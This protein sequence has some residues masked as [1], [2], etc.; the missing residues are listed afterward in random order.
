MKSF[1]F[2]AAL[3]TSTNALALFPRAEVP[4]CFNL[5][6]SGEVI[7]PLGQLTDGQSRVGD[8]SLSQSLF[9][10]NSTGVITDSTGKGCIITPET[11]Q[12]QCDEGKSGTPGFTIS[13]ASQLQF[14]GSE[15]FIACETGQNGGKNI[16]TTNSTSVTKCKSVIL[17]ADSC[18]NAGS[19]PIVGTSPAPAVP[20]APAP[21][22]TSVTSGAT[23]TA[24]APTGAPAATGAPA[25]SLSTHTSAATVIPVPVAP[26]PGQSSATSAG[27]ASPAA[28]SQ[29]SA[30]TTAHPTTPCPSCQ[31]ATS[32]A[33]QGTGTASPGPSCQSASSSSNHTCPSCSASG[34]NVTTTASGPFSSVT[35]F[36]N[37]T[38]ISSAPVTSLSTSI[39]P[40]SSVHANSTSTTAT[41]TSTSA[42]GCPTDLS[43]EFQ[44]PHLIV[45]IDSAKP[46]TPH[47]T[48]LN[49]TV[50]STVATTFNFDIPQSFSGKTCNLVF[51]FPR[52]EELQT[53][54][55]SFS[56]DGK[57]AFGK[58]SSTVTTSTTE[59][60]VPSVSQGLGTSAISP[61]HSFLISTFSCPA[62]QAIAFEMKSAG[63]T[64]FEFFE[65]WNPSPLGL[66]VTAC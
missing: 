20:V 50:N 4:C 62:G 12:F 35:G 56:G 17:T 11:T 47:G 39:H 2:L 26:A 66:F 7:G 36:A 51:L 29:T 40:S 5:N 21:G 65:D 14:H 43:G 44:F 60:N 16:Y 3:A 45:R 41:A 59:N 9:C 30:A 49:G 28:S 57:V 13:P 61:G 19:P 53:T 27:I 24:P 55:F 38:N 64:D 63:S 37:V 32:S 46:D 8:N 23:G 10:I 42:T 48:G 52:K 6:V 25:S 34:T 1:C 18:I 15:Y 33:T 22:H 58:L 31:S 54:S